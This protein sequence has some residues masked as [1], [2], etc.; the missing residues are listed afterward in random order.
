MSRISRLAFD[1][2]RHLAT[3]LLLVACALFTSEPFAADDQGVLYRYT[4]DQGV[5][6]MRHSI[7][8]Q[9]AQ[10]GYEI[11]NQSGQV[12]KVVPPAPTNEQIAVKEAERLLRERYASLKRRYSSIDDLE[13]AKARR[14]E[15]IETSIAI[16]RGN[17]N[18][19]SSQL[20]M[21][22]GRAADAERAGRQVPQHVLDQISATKAELDIAEELLEQRLNEMEEVEQKHQEDVITFVKGQAMEDSQSAHN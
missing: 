21:Q 17:I 14:I 18:S 12:V 9:Y 3:G 2:S 10:K 11:L 20:E 8:P 16:I 22:M 4:N 5:K 7:P 15:T 1:T 6:V 13:G 19:L